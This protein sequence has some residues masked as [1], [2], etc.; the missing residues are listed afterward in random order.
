MGTPA[1]AGINSLWGIVVDSTGTVAY[2]ADSSAKKIRVIDLVNF[3]VAAS[4]DLTGHPF[5]IAMHP[6]GRYVYVTTQIANIGGG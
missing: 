1:Q 2:L 4:I 5:A 3:K 6:T